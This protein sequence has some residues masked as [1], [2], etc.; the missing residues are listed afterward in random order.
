MRPATDVRFSLLT[1][2]ARTLLGLAV[3]MLSLVVAG[4]VLRSSL[5]A[6]SR[7][8]D[9]APAQGIDREQPPGLPKRHHIAALA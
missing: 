3:V 9:A 2:T 8:S 6:H 1:R 7:P 4:A 5:P